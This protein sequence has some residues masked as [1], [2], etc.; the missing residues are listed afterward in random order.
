MKSV[1]VTQ[2]CPQHVFHNIFPAVSSF[3]T[4]NKRMKGALYHTSD[5]RYLKYCER[6][7]FKKK[8]LKGEHLLKKRQCYVQKPEQLD[9]L[10]SKENIVK[11]RFI[12]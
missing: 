2:Y 4:K 10:V 12:F 7:Y 5:I 8:L 6:N 1:F 11:D 9:S 3:S